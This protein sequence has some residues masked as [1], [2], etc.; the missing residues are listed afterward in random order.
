MHRGYPQSLRGLDFRQ[1]VWDVRARSHLHALVACTCA[2]THLLR[3]L[4]TMRAARANVPELCVIVRRPLVLAPPAPLSRTTTARRP[5]ACLTPSLFSPLPRR[6]ESAPSSS[7]R[8]A[9]PP[10]SPAARGSRLPAAAASRS[11][12]P[13]WPP[14][15]RAR[16]RRW[17]RPG[18]WP[19]GARPSP[20]RGPREE[21]FR[22]GSVVCHLYLPAAS[23]R[24]LEVLVVRV[25]A[26]GVA[27]GRRL[28]TAQAGQGGALGQPRVE[29][30]EEGRRCESV[31]RRQMREAMER[32]EK[33]RGV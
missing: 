2:R 11:P 24:E 21:S 25:A 8:A 17:A 1:C 20:A 9:S 5:A 7:G 13:P 22:E 6:P 29:Q 16:A 12:T 19:R 3:G 32:V 26:G 28:H 18:R 27:L 31:N 10:S 4:C 14:P 33:K 23:W 15:A 30:P